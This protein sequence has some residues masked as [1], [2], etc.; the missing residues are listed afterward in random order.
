MFSLNIHILLE[1]N[2]HFRGEELRVLI[3]IK[4]LKVTKQRKVIKEKLNQKEI[5]KDHIQGLKDP[6]MMKEIKNLQENSKLDL[7]KSL[8]VQIILN[9]NKTI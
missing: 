9:K 6:N 2:F 4:L 8:K 3:L 5:N 1:V 7:K